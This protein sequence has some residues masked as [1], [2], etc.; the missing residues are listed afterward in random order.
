MPLRS[1]NQVI[2][3]GQMPPLPSLRAALILLAAVIPL[4]AIN[5]Q[6]WG[7]ASG[8]NALIAELG[9]APETHYS[10]RSYLE[11]A[12][13]S[14]RYRRGT[15]EPSFPVDEWRKPGFIEDGS[16][17]TGQTPMGYGDGD[18]NTLLY[19]QGSS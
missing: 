7:G 17:F 19:R 9:G 5:A 11:A 3:C 15:S 14:W 8:Y 10:A 2:D 12:D 13:S 18:D 4:A 16:W 1:I 6:N